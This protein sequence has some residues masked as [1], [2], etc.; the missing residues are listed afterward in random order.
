M[1][2]KVIRL[3]TSFSLSRLTITHRLYKYICKSC[4]YSWVSDVALS[5]RVFGISLEGRG[6]TTGLYREVDRSVHWVIVMNPSKVWEDLKNA[7]LAFCTRGRQCHNAG[8]SS[9]MATPSEDPYVIVQNEADLSTSD[10][11]MDVDTLMPLEIITLRRE[12][13]PGKKLQIW[14]TLRKCRQTKMV[15]STL[16]CAFSIVRTHRLQNMA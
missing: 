9:T 16:Q 8:I 11:D 6:S 1:L 13:S 14:R 12:T 4:A 3:P 2:P 10:D 15:S 7:V 5:R